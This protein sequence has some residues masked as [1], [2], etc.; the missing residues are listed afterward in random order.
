MEE[1]EKV[2]RKERETQRWE[3]EGEEEGND[4]KR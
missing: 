3:K 2:I 4:V 1:G